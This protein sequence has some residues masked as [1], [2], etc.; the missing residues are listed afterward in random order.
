MAL[1]AVFAGPFYGVTG[2]HG[3][4]AL[5]TFQQHSGHNLRYPGSLV[6]EQ[7]TDTI[8]LEASN[9]SEKINELDFHAAPPPT[10]SLRPSGIV[11]VEAA[12]RFRLGTLLRQALT[13]TILPMLS[14]KSC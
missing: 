3:E 7:K 2:C 12:A 5:F 14:R 8:R 9:Y 13:V 10:L 11:T 6:C 1:V 4:N